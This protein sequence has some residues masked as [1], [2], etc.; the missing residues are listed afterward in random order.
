MTIIN[1]EGMVLAALYSTNEVAAT[2]LPIGTWAGQA[3]RTMLRAIVPVA[4]GDVLD[5]DG[6][7]RPTNNAALP[8]YTV[9]VTYGL[10][11]YDVD[12]GLGSAGTWWH[13]GPECGDNV[14]ADRHHLPIAL[15]SV[16][17]VPDDWPAGHRIVIVLR[18]DAASTAA[19]A[20][21]ALTADPLGT[22]TVRR[23]TTPDPTPQEGP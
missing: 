18:A 12:N 17:A 19:R 4:A 3:Y 1:T 10:W 14:S 13:I 8:R 20:G 9:G 2:T 6:W 16:Y 21:D 15:T 23:W 5:V 22:L 11:A 7:S